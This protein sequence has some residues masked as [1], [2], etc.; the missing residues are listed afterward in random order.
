MNEMNEADIIVNDEDDN[1]VNTFNDM[2]N[3]LMNSIQTTFN[4]NDVYDSKMF[5][6]DAFKE[7]IIIYF[8][9]HIDIIS[10]G[11]YEDILYDDIIEM[12][13]VL[14][15]NCELYFAKHTY[16]RSF[17]DIFQLAIRDI[18]K[19]YIPI[20]QYK[21]SYIRKVE[22][23][24]DILTNKKNILRNIPQPEQRTREWYEFRHTLISASN[25]WKCFEGEKVVNQIIYEKCKP[26]I[27]NKDENNNVFSINT[28][29][30]LHWGQK[31]EPLSVMLY[32]EKYKT[33][34]EDFGC[35][36]HSKH[37]FMGA[38]PDG[39]NVDV[40]SK[41]YGRMLEI[42]NI[43][44]REITKIP[45][46]EYWIQMQLQ[47]ETCDLNEC[48]FLET[49]FNEL[50]N[51]EDY[52]NH[53]GTKGVLLHYICNNKIVYEYSPVK[54]ND[55]EYTKW[56]ETMFKTHENDMFVKHIYWKLETFS[57]ILVLR[58]KKWFNKMIHTIENVWNIILKERVS[59]YEHRQPNKRIKKVT[60]EKQD[61]VNRKCLITQS[62]NEELL[63][64]SSEIMNNIQEQIHDMEKLQNELISKTEKSK[65][66]EEEEIDTPISQSPQNKPFIKIRTESFDE[67]KKN[68]I[69]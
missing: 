54:C 30:P 19:R 33:Q 12:I 64:K 53:E 58:N 44:S 24:I 34:I 21:D 32:E 25:A 37:H 9:Q 48:D 28:K 68:N 46:K 59:G 62:V 61:I 29:S 55:E 4:L 11:N 7:N 42:K 52:N 66:T 23:D 1:N 6:Y 36:R 49:K 50:E 47:M 35:I 27:I 57:C 2:D 22:L 67:Y 5:L 56:E 3:D 18:Y 26:L 65:K 16:H 17:M 51:V 40:K 38:S 31:Y 41:R 60:E 39:I 14:I 10:N 8:D 45:K 63:E 20:R 43:V 13:Y 69:S 15:E